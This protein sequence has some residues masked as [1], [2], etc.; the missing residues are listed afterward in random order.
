MF[1]SLPWKLHESDQNHEHQYRLHGKYVK[2]YNSENQSYDIYSRDYDSESGKI[3]Y[4]K[5]DIKTIQNVPSKLYLTDTS[6][7]PLSSNNLYKQGRFTE[8]KQAHTDGN[9]N[10]L[11]EC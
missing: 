3:I 7:N 1:L 2:V 8:F 9:I 4:S 10:I 6:I 11:I 5:Y